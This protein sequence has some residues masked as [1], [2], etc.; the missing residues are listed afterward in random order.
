[1]LKALLLQE[2][3]YVIH[4][5]LER[6]L[7]DRILFHNFS[8]DSEKMPNAQIMWALHGYLSNPETDKS[9]WKEFWSQLGSEGIVIQRGIMQDVP[10]ITFDS[11]G[12]EMKKPCGSRYSCTKGI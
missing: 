10:L 4:E 7:Y 1:M 5:R 3:Y 6:G 9:I 12:N 11:G 8:Y 2:P